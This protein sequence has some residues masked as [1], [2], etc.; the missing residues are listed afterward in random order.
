MEIQSS[1]RIDAPLDRVWNVLVDIPRVARCLPGTENVQQVDDKTYKADVSLKVGPLSVNYRATITRES[2]DP[3][4]HTA[5]MKIDAT[6][7]KG[8]GNASA[9]VTTSARAE[10]D[11]TAIDVLADAKIS[12]VLGQFG[13]GVIKDVA[14]RVMKQFAVK[15][16][17]EA[18][19]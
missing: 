17:D 2:I 3:V 13:Q 16:A 18:K 6:D 9:T 1:A 4:A 15:V 11:G 5:Q 8:R 10:G 14:G 7:V 19:T 12:G